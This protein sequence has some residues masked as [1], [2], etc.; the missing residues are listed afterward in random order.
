[1]AKVHNL[2]TCGELTVKLNGKVNSLAHFSDSETVEHLSKMGINEDLIERAMQAAQ[3]IFED[4]GANII[5]TQLNVEEK[6]AEMIDKC[7]CGS[8]CTSWGSE[9][10]ESCSIGADGKTYCV[11][12]TRTVCTGMSCNPC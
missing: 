10:Y 11:R 7:A 4:F 8:R 12:G 3:K 2:E 1:M 9:P 6:P 5:V